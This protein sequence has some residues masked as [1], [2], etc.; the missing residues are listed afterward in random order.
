MQENRDWR[1]IS[2]LA[3]CQKST[4]I[5]EPGFYNSESIYTDNTDSSLKSDIKVHL[6][7]FAMS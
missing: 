6:G 7:Q 1:S 5:C 2:D 4:G 3:G